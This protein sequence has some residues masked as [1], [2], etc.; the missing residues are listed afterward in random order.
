MF[1]PIPDAMQERMR[2]LELIDEQDRKDGTGHNERLRQI[3]PVT[4]R[5]LA[6]LAAGAP[7]GEIIEIGTSAGYST[8]WISLACRD[9][10]RR[11]TT[12]EVLDNKI[13]IA[14]ETIELAGI[15]DLVTLVH[16]DARAYIA[17]MAPIAFCF[18]DAE[19]DVYQ[20]C[21]DRVV[22]NMTPGGLLLVDN[23][24]SHAQYLESFVNGAALDKRVDAVVVPI[25]K[26][27]LFCRKL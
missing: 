7:G 1:H 27:L 12:F 21:Y 9:T 23:V 13:A 25:G 19:K 8:M 18:L 2:Y 6:L 24:I 11:M 15:K 22:S 10:N 4:G 26:G 3:P 5:F 16:G 14:Q 17:E 20:D